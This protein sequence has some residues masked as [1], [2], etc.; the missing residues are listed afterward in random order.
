MSDFLQQRNSMVDGQI[1]PNGVTDP[2]ITD[3]MRAVPREA[4]VPKQKQAIAYMDEVIEVAAGRYAMEPMFL[5]KLVQAL[6]VEPT[7]SVLII[8]SGLGYSAAVLGGLCDAVIG[9]ED[10]QALT[11]AA[12]DILADT[13]IDNAAIVTGPLTEG[14]ASQAPY[15]VIMIDGGYEA[16]PEG[17]F[18]QLAEDGRLGG[19]HVDGR[20]GQAEVFVKTDGVVSK[21]AAFDAVVPLLPG[22]TTPRGFV[23]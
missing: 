15:D 8:G 12:S 20:A 19:I 2:R 3:R 9:L 11:D 4:F 1:R 22:F 6:D 14:F 16:V 10:D 7:D 5:A 17:L 21:R 18:D 23:L 13:G